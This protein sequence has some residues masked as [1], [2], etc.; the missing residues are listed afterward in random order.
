MISM[1]AAART[2]PQTGIYLGGRSEAIW[3]EYNEDAITDSVVRKTKEPIICVHFSRSSHLVRGVQ[4]ITMRAASG[5]V[6]VSPLGG[7]D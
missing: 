3:R 6:R 2:V 5:R 1:S 7:I 4:V